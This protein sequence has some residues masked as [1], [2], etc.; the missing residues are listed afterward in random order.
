MPPLPLHP[1]TSYIA[2]RSNHYHPASIK[3]RN[4][5]HYL[6]RRKYNIIR[7]LN[8]HNL[9][10]PKSKADYPHPSNK[11]IKIMYY[12]HILLYKQNSKPN[13]TSKTQFPWR[14]HNSAHT[15]HHKMRITITNI[16]VYTY[17]QH[18]LIPSA[19]RKALVNLINRI[20]NHYPNQ[21]NSLTAKYLVSQPKP[22]YTNPLTHYQSQY[23]HT[24]PKPNTPTQTNLTQLRLHVNIC[25]LMQSTTTTSTTSASPHILKTNSQINHQLKLT[26]L[27]LKCPRTCTHNLANPKIATKKEA[28]ML[29]PTKV[30]RQLHLH[31]EQTA[32]S[33]QTR[34]SATKQSRNI[35]TTQ[36]PLPKNPSNKF[37]LT[38]N[39]FNRHY[40]AVIKPCN[41]S[42]FQQHH[43][44]QNKLKLIEQ[45]IPRTNK[46]TINSCNLNLNLLQTKTTIQNE[47]P[48]SIYKLLPTQSAVLTETASNI[49]ATTT[50]QK[51]H[52]KPAQT[53]HMQ[54]KQSLTNIIKLTC[55]KIIKI[56]IKIITFNL[57]AI[58]N[59]TN[60]SYSTYQ[61]NNT[62]NRQTYHPQSYNQLI[63]AGLP[64][65]NHH[66]TKI[67]HQFISNLTLQH[68]S[69]YTKCAKETLIKQLIKDN[70]PAY[71]LTW[72][73]QQP[74]NLGFKAT[75]KVVTLKNTYLKA[76]TTRLQE[77]FMRPD[78]HSHNTVVH[79][80]KANHHNKIQLKKQTSVNLNNIA[81]PIDTQRKTNVPDKS[82][83]TN[84]AASSGSATTNPTTPTPY[85]SGNLTKYKYRS[86]RPQHTC[87]GK[88]ETYSSPKT[89]SLK[90]TKT[91]NYRNLDQIHS[92]KPTN[93]VIPTQIIYHNPHYEVK[94]VN[95][96]RMQRPLQRSKSNHPKTLVNSQ[97]KSIDQNVHNMHT[98]QTR[99][100][101]QP[102]NGLPEIYENHNALRRQPTNADIPTPINSPNLGPASHPQA[103]QSNSN[104]CPPTSKANVLHQHKQ[105]TTITTYPGILSS[106]SPH[107]KPA[108]S[109]KP[110]G[111]KL[112]KTISA[113]CSS[114]SDQFLPATYAN[115]LSTKLH[116]TCRHA[117]PHAPQ[118]LKPLPTKGTSKILQANHSTCKCPATN[119]THN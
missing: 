57:T 105:V 58:L 78:N 69:E 97:I 46:L 89:G 9:I 80:A 33:M 37:L 25:Q 72:L 44:N 95:L 61:T 113:T 118:P 53:T 103:I 101:Q 51:K 82:S 65:R 29:Q 81:T 41:T 26:N 19:N 96:S 88:S 35:I 77:H 45:V 20:N 47:N 90:S 6:D 62:K 84:V 12:I 83:F 30:N 42:K 8:Q 55:N 48:A 15:K 16:T 68:Q 70:N 17:T 13:N 36:K 91:T 14:K 22:S 50:V 63:T 11:T 67:N 49:R 102:K 109:H 85:V 112:V 27:S 71:M 24:K 111:N 73:S 31:T 100:L 59:Y 117:R 5:T 79:I 93:A 74:R 108:R 56:N 75:H 1:K 21:T 23:L 104:L 54:R 116:I 92:S 64:Y 43:I 98:R 32:L 39:Q 38:I 76:I 18:N 87:L 52:I 3:S 10:Q 115:K 106:T 86:K 107:H 119:S 7:N 60:Q 34:M 4:N 40:P 28:Y 114:K 94:P 66:P 2:N 110:A 99:T